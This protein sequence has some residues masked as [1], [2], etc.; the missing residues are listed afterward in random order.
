MVNQNI[1][2]AFRSV[3]PKH[4]RYDSGWINVAKQVINAI[5]NKPWGTAVRWWYSINDFATT[6]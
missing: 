3:P 2:F 4:S 6:G 5:A 1:A